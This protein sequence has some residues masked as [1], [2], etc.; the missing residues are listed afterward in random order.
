MR[1]T[2]GF[3]RGPGRR[4]DSGIP[5][6]P[7]IG[8]DFTRLEAE[9]F[10]PP[11]SCSGPEKVRVER[12]EAMGQVKFSDLETLIIVAEQH[13]FRRAAQE[14]GISPSRVSIRIKELEATLGV[15]L[16]HRNTRHVSLTGAGEELVRRA[17]TSLE[18]LTL[19][20]DA[21]KE[22][23]AS[24]FGSVRI[25]VQLGVPYFSVVP[26]LV[27]FL[28]TFPSVELDIISNGHFDDIVLDRCDV[29]LMV[30]GKIPQDMIA[31]PVA[32]V[33]P[34][35]VVGSPAYLE[36]HGVPL[37]PH[38]LFTHECLG[39]AAV[40]RFKNRDEEFEF[41]PSSRLRCEN[42]D[43]SLEAALNDSGLIYRAPQDV[44]ALAQADR[45]VRVLADWVAPARQVWLYYASRQH[46]SAAVAAFVDY[47][48]ASGE[49]IFPGEG[50]LGRSTVSLGG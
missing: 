42:L 21:I 2:N 28:E 26:R 49:L 23:G 17:R 16:L 11:S 6:A 8:R 3:R 38:D 22:L 43:I 7:Y 15:R 9:R 40:W 32:R 35:W 20:I 37:H 34:A 41:M 18:R 14:L 47:M 36:R 10:W 24:L 29:A 44:E 12:A 39:P 45:L 5:V 1:V 33:G 13:G 4:R 46:P 48:R 30:R 50:G 27:R 25:G 19:D 31:T